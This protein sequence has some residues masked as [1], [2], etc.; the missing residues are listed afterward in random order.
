MTQARLQTS[1]FLEHNLNDII[2]V[3]INGFELKKKISKKI[4]LETNL[5]LDNLK[6]EACE[7]CPCKVTNCLNKL[8]EF[9]LFWNFI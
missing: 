2:Y 6:F 1:E 8:L 9:I 3:H 5:A 7:D 4:K